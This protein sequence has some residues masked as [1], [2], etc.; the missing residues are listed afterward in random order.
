MRKRGIRFPIS[1]LTRLSNGRNL[2]VDNSS[3]N[4]FQQPGCFFQNYEANITIGKDVYIAANVGVITQNH[5]PANP[6]EHL[7]AKEVV[8][9]DNCWIGMNAVIL[10]GVKLGPYTTVGAGSVVTHSFEDGYCVIAGNPAR[11]IR[12]FEVEADE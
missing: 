5:N 6:N 9:G 4:V 10:P 7:P 11:L 3:L 2:I 12:K 1:E 8:I